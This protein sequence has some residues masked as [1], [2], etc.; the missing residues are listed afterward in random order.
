[1]SN[2]Q[3]TDGIAGFTHLCVGVFRIAADDARQLAEHIAP[4]SCSASAWQQ[5]TNS[6]SP[7]TLCR[8]D[9]TKTRLRVRDDSRQAVRYGF[10]GT[11]SF[12]VTE[13]RGTVI[14]EAGASGDIP[15]F[16]SAAAQVR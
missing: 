3:A 13:S 12:A 8:P 2:I 4:C 15:A 11:P 5:T 9:G 7:T 6:T 10:Q 16:E 14:V 1:M